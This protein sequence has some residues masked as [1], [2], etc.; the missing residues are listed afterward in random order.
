[1]HAYSD[2]TG[3]PFYMFSV[4]SSNEPIDEHFPVPMVTTLNKV[5]RLL[6]ESTTSIAKLE[7]PEKVVN[8]FEVWSN[9]EYLVD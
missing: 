2:T 4:H 8:F 3:V 7:R 5:T 6:P 9:S 1:M